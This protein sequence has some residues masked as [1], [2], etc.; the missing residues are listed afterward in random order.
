MNEFNDLYNVLFTGADKYIEIVRLLSMH[1]EGM[2]RK[3]LAAELGINGG[4]LTRRLENLENCDFIIGF[5][6]FGN[7]KKGSIIR[8]TDFFTLFYLKFIEG[9]QKHTSDYWRNMIRTPGVIAWQGLTFELVGLMHIEQIKR[10]LGI[11]AVATQTSSWR[12]RQ[13]NAQIDLV[14]DRADRCIH[15]CEMKFSTTPFII[16]KE[17]EMRI[18]ERMAIFLEETRTSRTLLSTFVTTFGVSPGIHS[19]V[20]QSEVTLDDLFEPSKG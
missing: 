6:Q 1:R 13:G 12:S 14:I 5:S 18:R 16:T 17:Y 19:G 3:Q 4:S 8:L 20:V 11:G 9:T 15:L 10:S 2:T 7:K